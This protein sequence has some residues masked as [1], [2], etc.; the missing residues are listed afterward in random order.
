MKVVT[1]LVNPL[2]HIDTGNGKCQQ[3][4][5]DPWTQVP[6]TIYHFY[7]VRFFAKSSQTQ[8]IKWMLWGLKG[9]HPDMQV[10]FHACQFIAMHPQGKW[11]MSA[12]II[13]SMDRGTQHNVSF[14]SSVFCLICPK[15]AH[16]MG[17]VGPERDA[18]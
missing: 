7:P 8:L 13:S 16:P 6:T 4:S 15:P 2:P 1:K 12:P 18:S 10:M 9:M 3:Q 17:A 5:S 14:L 11:N